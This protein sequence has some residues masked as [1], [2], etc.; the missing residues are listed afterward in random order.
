[1]I[2]IR[3]F[4][5]V[6][7]IALLLAPAGPAQADDTGLRSVFSEGT[8]NRALGMGGAFV[9]LADDA[10][11]PLWN[12]G[13]LGFIDRKQVQVTRA[14]LYGLGIGEEF[15]GI[16][17]PD[18]RFGT[19]ALTFR[20][21]GLAGIEQRDDR[22]VLLADDLS[23]SQVELTLS[24]GR[25][26]GSAWSLGGTVKLMNHRLAGYSGTA[27]AVDMGVLIHPAS[28]ILTDREWLAPLTVGISVRNLVDSAM[29]LDVDETRDPSSGKIGFAYRF[30]MAD[31]RSVTAAL[32][33]EEGPGIDPVVSAGMEVRLHSLLALRTGYSRNGFHAGAGVYW[34][35]SSF[36][37]TFEDNDFDSVHRLGLS[38]TFG[39][40]VEE[41]RNAALRAKEEALNARMEEAFARRQAQRSESLLSDAEEARNE[42]RYEDAL[43]LLA[44]VS[45][46]EPENQDV[47]RARVRCLL[48]KASA[49]ESA[50][51][52]GEAAVTYGEV[53]LL[54]PDDTVSASGFT[55]CREQSD[56]RAA[57]TEKIRNIFAGALNALSSGD[58]ISARTGFRAVLAEQPD[59]AETSALLERTEETID[60]RVEA[61]VDQAERFTGAGL[62]DEADKS[63]DQARRFGVNTGI[64][65]R[66]AV[67]LEKASAR[68]RPRAQTADPGPGSG[69]TEAALSPQKQEEIRDLYQRG[70]EAM[71]EGRSEDALRYWE[72]VASADPGH[73]QVREYLK[74]EYLTRGMDAFAAGRLETAAEFWQKALHLDPTD[75]KAKGYLARARQ[76]LARSQEIHGATG[77]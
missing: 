28:L 41:S 40:T 33:L 47:V 70:L 18:H 29:R 45:T 52:Y 77:Q 71:A 43:D 75:E 48:D 7:L 5:I 65:T 69:E 23:D 49:Q 2:A 55:R 59:D 31:G 62:F 4:P 34:Q 17:V 6:L 39:P 63:L 1:M 67:H 20:H 10:S 64:I 73:E 61:L 56:M 35:N 66:A 68:T 8:G 50:G 15:V 25:A 42:G 76:Q 13:G 51:S 44:V 3:R 9:G 32:D 11:A 58:L 37:Y 19:A 16:V 72:L 74:R 57:R 54:A 24:Y 27:F 53:Q 38:W 46:L 12:P 21:L 60:R 26:L 22:N 14:S 30:P 36:D